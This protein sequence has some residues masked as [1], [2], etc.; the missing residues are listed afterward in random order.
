MEFAKASPASPATTF[1]TV[2]DLEKLCDTKFARFKKMSTY[3]KQ[4]ATENI[5]RLTFPDDTL[6]RHISTSLP[7]RWQGRGQ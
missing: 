2:D 4:G 6:R 5:R 3:P 7:G 1:Y